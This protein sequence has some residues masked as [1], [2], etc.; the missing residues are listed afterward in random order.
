MHRFAF[1]S[2]SQ[3]CIGAD[4]HARTHKQ[5]FDT[6]MGRKV[7][8]APAL[9]LPPPRAKKVSFFPLQDHAPTQEEQLIWSDP[10]TELWSF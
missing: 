8:N 3:P 4:D 9:D 7:K 2:A 10:V 6:E 5:M 1:S